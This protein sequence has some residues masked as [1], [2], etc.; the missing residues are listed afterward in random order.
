VRPPPLEQV[1]LGDADH[2]DAL[3]GTDHEDALGETDHEDALGGTDHEDALG[4]TDTEMRSV[5][6][7]WTTPGDTADCLGG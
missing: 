2:E 5:G 3:G 1:A 7:R 6:R 4:A